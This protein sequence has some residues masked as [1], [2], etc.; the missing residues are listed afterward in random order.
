MLSRSERLSL[1]LAGFAL[2]EG[3]ARASAGQP[4]QATLAVRQLGAFRLVPL[5]TDL[6]ARA[7][8][9]VLLA[10][11]GDSI[12]C[13]AVLRERHVGLQRRL[14]VSAWM[15]GTW[16]YEI[17]LPF[18]PGSRLRVKPERIQ[19]ALGVRTQEKLARDAVYSGVSGHPDGLRAWAAADI[20]I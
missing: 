2:A 11:V 10:A 5:G 14:H 19:D 17:E 13:A 6:S 7:Q 15:N 1:E 4:V 3:I 12:D 16:R 18:Q 20:D 9:S 8:A